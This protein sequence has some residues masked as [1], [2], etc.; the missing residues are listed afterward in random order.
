MIP[1]KSR[2]RQAATPSKPYWPTFD[3]YVRGPDDIEGLIAYGLYKFA[4]ITVLKGEAKASRTNIEFWV[5]T[6]NQAH[7]I[8][9]RRD[10]AARLLNS[11]IINSTREKV[12][13]IRER[14]DSTAKNR[15]DDYMRK[16]DTLHST[17][18]SRHTSYMDKLDILERQTG[19]GTFRTAFSKFLRDIAVTVASLFVSYILYV[20]LCAYLHD[21][22]TT[23]LLKDSFKP[24]VPLPAVVEK[25]A[26]Q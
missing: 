3:N 25:K 19:P 24:I 14:L 10:A 23:Q 1:S 12:E 22:S 21:L 26:T 9:Q 2:Q 5:S 18:E 6:E 15:H 11:L 7:A 4:K 13:D 20:A 17:A 16:F 8:R